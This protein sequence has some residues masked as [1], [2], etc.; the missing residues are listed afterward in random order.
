MNKGF[1]LIELVASIV[2][3]SILALLAFPAILNVLNKSNQNVNKALKQTLISSAE[4]Y[5]N[6]NKN[7]FPKPIENED[8]IV[9]EIDINVLLENGYIDKELYKKY[10]EIE[11]DSIT[12]K[13]TTYKYEYQYNDKEDECENLS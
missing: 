10:C 8:D 3:L 2:I 5:V 1:T 7:S 9:K 12:V 4:E 6:D 13:A 11:N